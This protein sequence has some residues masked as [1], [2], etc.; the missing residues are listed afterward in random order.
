MGFATWLNW[1][2]TRESSPR[3]PGAT[4][5]APPPHSDSRRSAVLERDRRHRGTLPRI[6][7]RQCPILEV[8]DPD[9]RVAGCDR[10]RPDAGRDLRDDFVRLRVDKA[11]VV[12]LS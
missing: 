11:D 6:D 10:P 8:A 9:R 3:R 12:R 5:T 1:G 2:S 4:Q 7:P